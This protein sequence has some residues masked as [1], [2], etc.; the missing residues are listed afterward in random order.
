M[1]ETNEFEVKTVA[2]YIAYKVCRMLFQLN[3]A[4]DA[5]SQFK[6]HVEHYKHLTG[7]PLLLFQHHAWLSK[8]LVIYTILYATISRYRDQDFYFKYLL[9][10]CIQ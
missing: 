8:Q 7:A 4:R 5:I 6:A 9:F 1:T 3:K 2:G 10:M